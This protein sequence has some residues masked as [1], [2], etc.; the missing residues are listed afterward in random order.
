M[1]DTPEDTPAHMPPATPEALPPENVQRGTLLALLVIPAGI[2]VWVILWGFGFIASLVAFGIAIG[3][4]WLYRFGSDGRISR[5]GA[6]RVTLVTVVALILAFVAGLVSEV[7]PMYANQRNLDFVSALTSGEFWSFFNNA[8]ANNFGDVA[9]QFVIALAF[10]ALGCFSV[11]RTA[12]RQTREMEAGP[13]TD[14][15]TG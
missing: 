4:L 1:S 12:F 7:L 10:G 5:A 3:A 15:T 13:G 2:V 14:Q 6:V 9:V 8:V 11:L